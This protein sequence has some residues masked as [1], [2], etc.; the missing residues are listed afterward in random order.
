MQRKRTLTRFE[1]TFMTGL[2]HTSEGQV[3]VLAHETTVVPSTRLQIGI[4]RLR[5]RGRGLGLDVKTDCFTAEP[6]ALVVA[7]TIDHGHFHALIEE[8]AQIFETVA[9]DEVASVAECYIRR[10]KRWLNN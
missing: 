5:E 3:A 1:L 10:Q 7:V 6:V 8:S 4:A 2:I 9:A